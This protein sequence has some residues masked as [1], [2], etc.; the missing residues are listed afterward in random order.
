MNDFCKVSSYCSNKI[1]E[2]DSEKNGSKNSSKLLL[3]LLRFYMNQSVVQLC[4]ILS[5]NELQMKE[6][7]FFVTILN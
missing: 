5:S 7:D 4:R 3:D 6:V 2:T 1:L